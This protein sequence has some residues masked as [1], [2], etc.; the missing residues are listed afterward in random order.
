MRGMTAH[1]PL[2]RSL[3]LRERKKLRTRRALADAALRLFTQKGFDATTLEEVAEEAEVSKSTFFRF[4][5]AKE[6]A[7]IE[8][9]TELWTAY[10][11]ALAER[12]LSGPVLGELHQALAGAAAGLDPGWDQRFLAAR[13]LILAEPNTLL[14]YVEHYRAGIKNQVVACLAG[15]LRLDSEDLRLHVLAEL[16]M[17][18]FSLA[19]R[20]WVQRGGQGGREALLERHRE[21]VKAIPASLDLSAPVQPARDGGN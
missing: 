1:V 9:E 20:P 2:D 12:E 4:F 15:K 10:L 11:A 21:A 16:A 17:T 8:A 14:K 7:A 18:A 5:P 3:P 19:G 6:A 13:R